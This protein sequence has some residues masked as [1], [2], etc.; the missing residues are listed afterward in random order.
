MRLYPKTQTEYL[1]R[2]FGT[3]LKYAVGQVGFLRR[4]LIHIDRHW[5]EVIPKQVHDLLNEIE[6]KLKG[7]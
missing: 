2:S 7:L 4:Q 5:P 3:E 6:R 1:Q